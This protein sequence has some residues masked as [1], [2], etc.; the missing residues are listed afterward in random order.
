MT[1]ERRSIE[2]SVMM[3]II[4]IR[5]IQYGSFQRHVATAAKDI[6]FNL[7]SIKFNLISYSH[8][9]PEA[10]ELHSPSTLY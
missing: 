9:W 4:Y 10:V 3:E 6:N 1:T 5:V 8:M 2:C 7:S